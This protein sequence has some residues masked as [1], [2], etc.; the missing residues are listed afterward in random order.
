M[1]QAMAVG[2]Q[3]G[4]DEFLL[5]YFKDSMA[6]GFLVDVGAADGKDNSNSY[7]LLKKPRW[8]GI[9]IEPE[10]SQFKELQ[11]RYADAFLVDCVNCAVGREERERVLYCARQVST[12]DPAWRDRC[13]KAYELV[14]TETVVQI[15]TLTQ[16]LKEFR[17][18]KNIDFLSID[19]EGM[20]MEVLASLDLSLFSPHLVCLEGRGHS[21]SGYQEIH[22]TRGN[23][24]YKRNGNGRF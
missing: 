13:I 20:D 2:S 24:F 15:R 16:I 21:I 19:C 12:F 10:P 4:E 22:Q 11:S 23:T 5:K 7:Y 1:E 18:P 17:A 9:L 8:Q 14:F 6:F 3:Y